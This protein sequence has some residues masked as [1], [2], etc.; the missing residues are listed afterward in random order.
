LA[1]GVGA[2]GEEEDAGAG[3]G[4]RQVLSSEPAEEGRVLAEPCPQ[5]PFLG[6]AAGKQ[7][8][9]SWIGALGAE[10]ALGEQIDPLLVGSAGR[11]RAS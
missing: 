11:R 8:V 10:E 9:Q 7:Q 2:A 6:P 1:V 3:V 4:A 5:L